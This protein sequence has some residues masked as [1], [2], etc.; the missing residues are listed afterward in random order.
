MPVSGSEPSSQR[1]CGKTGASRFGQGVNESTGP[2]QRLSFVPRCQMEFM[3]VRHC[4][5]SGNT[6]AS[7]KL[8]AWCKEITETWG[9]R[10]GTAGRD[11][12]IRKEWHCGAVFFQRILLLAGAILMTLHSTVSNPYEEDLSEALLLDPQS[13]PR[14]LRRRRAGNQDDARVIKWMWENVKRGFRGGVRSFEG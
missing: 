7:R 6:R 12:I 3:S 5:R 1:L 8:L 11:R 4:Y 2:P 10:N 9:S 13:Q 14:A